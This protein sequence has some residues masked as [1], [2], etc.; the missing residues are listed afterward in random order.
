VYKRKVRYR[1]HTES[2]SQKMNAKGKERVRK[3]INADRRRMYDE[4]VLPR[5]AE[6]PFLLRHHARV[7]RFFF[8]WLEK[9]ER[10]A[11]VHWARSLSLVIDPYRLW[12]KLEGVFGGSV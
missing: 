9:T 5:M 1:L 11:L 2:L 12:R 3:G 6:Q 8:A 10:P 4:I 7:R